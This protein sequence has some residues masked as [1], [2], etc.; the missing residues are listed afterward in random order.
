VSQVGLGLGLITRGLR[1]L[2]FAPLIRENRKV[3]KEYRQHLK[4]IDAPFDS[5]FEKK[6]WQCTTVQIAGLILEQM[7]YPGAMALQ[8]VAAAERNRSVT[9]DPLYGTPF[10]LAE[11]L[12]D[13]YMEGHEI[14]TTTPPW[15]G[16]EIAIPAEVRGNLLA[17]LKRTI[18]DNNRV[19]WL[20]KMG[21]DLSPETSPE[22]FVSPS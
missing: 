13:A 15:V 5:D 12:S 19:E 9:P 20:D 4:T 16:Q 17:A 6:A 22:M 2:A 18:E 10:R 8:Y 14:P 7:G 1:Y 3:F 11:C 21:I